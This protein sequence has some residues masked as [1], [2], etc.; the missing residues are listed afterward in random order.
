MGPPFNIRHV[1]GKDSNK[2]DILVWITVKITDLLRYG[3]FKKK[4]PGRRFGDESVSLTC[5][6][7]YRELICVCFAV[8]LQS[9]SNRHRKNF[10]ITRQHNPQILILCTTV[11]NPELNSL[12]RNNSQKFFHKNFRPA[13]IFLLLSIII[14]HIHYCLLHVSVICLQNGICKTSSPRL[15]Y[16][17]S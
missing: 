8:N 5:M 16:K 2:S 14:Y 3:N 7:L 17:S 12:L 6:Q 15:K 11:Y 1:H 9:L 4:T 10:I 13:L